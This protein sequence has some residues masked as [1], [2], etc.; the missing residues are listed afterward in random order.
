MCLLGYGTAKLVLAFAEKG[1]RV[2]V[3]GGESELV[4]AIF[5]DCVAARE[6]TVDDTGGNEDG[7]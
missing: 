4:E 7:A 5:V 1:R 6:T 3:W 2:F